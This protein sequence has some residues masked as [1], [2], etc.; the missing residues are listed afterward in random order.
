MRP[1][2]Q[3]ALTGSTVDMVAGS[4]RK[5]I[6]SGVR[7][8]LLP[9]LAPLILLPLALGGSPDPALAQAHPGDTVR[10][11]H[12]KSRALIFGVVG[13]L[14]GGLAGLE[15]GKGSNSGGQMTI[16]GAATGGLGG[17]FVGRQL[18]K[19]KAAMFG[20]TPSLRVPNVAAGLEGDAAVLTV[21]DS[22]AAIGGSTG[23]Q[24]FSAMDVRLMPIGTRAAGLHGIGAIDLAPRSGWMALGSRTGLY[25]Y[26]PRQGPG[27]LVRRANVSAV[28]AAE[29]RIYVALENRVE[30]V[31]VNADST[32]EWRG[33]TLS[34]PVR[35]IFV[36]EARAMVWASTDRELVALH[37]TG[38]SLVNI[39]SVPLSGI[40]LRVTVSGAVAA[41]AMGE[42]GVAIIDVT[43]AAHP[44]SRG[45]W[46]TARFAYDVSIDGAR[47]F[48]AA[49]PE[50]V[51]LVNLTP[52]G[53]H[54][55]GLARALGF[56]SAVVSYDGHTFILDRRTN[57][58]RRIISTY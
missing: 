55:V 56:A 9:R 49:G 21:R 25:I 47:M 29:T 31:P 40:G 45:D 44:K 37:I 43:D 50:G 13:A 58:L 27:V 6:C 51:Y 53:P 4:A 41:V 15:F 11:A 35:D 39:G 52:E 14:I 12:P 16:I 30:S 38:D 10:L 5:P 24:L 34:A 19:R 36:D 17:F 28:A 20:G 3:S 54:T 8:P 23:V 18:D 48:V 46:T 26:P 7:R 33:T 1:P 57:A 22:I 32:R 42:K 2:D